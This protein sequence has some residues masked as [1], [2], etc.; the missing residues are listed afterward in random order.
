MML[1][2]TLEKLQRAESGIRTPVGRPKAEA[3]GP[4]TSIVPPVKKKQGALVEMHR[5]LPVAISQLDTS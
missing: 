2:G 1:V 3:P 4:V 5:V